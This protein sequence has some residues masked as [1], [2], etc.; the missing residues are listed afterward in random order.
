MFHLFRSS[1]LLVAAHFFVSTNTYPLDLIEIHPLSSTHKDSNNGQFISKFHFMAP[2][3]CFKKNSFISG[4]S[5]ISHTN[6]QSH[7]T[8]YDDDGFLTLSVCLRF[9]QEFLLQHN[10]TKSQSFSDSTSF[11]LNQNILR[12]DLFIPLFT[13][14]INKLL[15]EELDPSNTVHNPLTREQASSF[16]K[17]CEYAPTYETFFSTFGNF[18]NS[19]FPFRI[20]QAT[21]TQLKSSTEGIFKISSLGIHNTSF[22]ERDRL[23]QSS[24]MNCNFTNILS[25]LQKHLLKL[26]KS[27]FIDQNSRN[28]ITANPQQ[29]KLISQL[30]NKI[31][32]RQDLKKNH[33]LSGIDIWHVLSS[34]ALLHKDTHLL[35]NYHSLGLE[36]SPSIFSSL[37]KMIK[38]SDLM[39]FYSLFL[40][41]NDLDKTVIP[42]D[43][44]EIEVWFSL[45]SNNKETTKIINARIASYTNNLFKNIIAENDL[46][47]VDMAFYTTSYLKTFWKNKFD[48]EISSHFFNADNT[49][50]TIKFLKKNNLNVSYS[51]SNNNLTLMLPLKNNAHYMIWMPDKLPKK[52]PYLCPNQ[53]FTTSKAD[54]T[55]PKLD[56]ESATNLITALKDLNFNTLEG[57]YLSH[58]RLQSIFQKVKLRTTLDGVEAAAVTST[59]LTSSSQDEASFLINKPHMISIVLEA[60]KDFFIPMFTGWIGNL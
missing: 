42:N 55:Y 31:L 30:T 3:N 26:P 16:F 49:Q 56:V 1:F 2:D 20:F 23:W 17:L 33:L 27:L 24:L 50:T 7:L 28:V 19:N 18:V 51:I 9:F 12:P 14:S 41:P 13:L 32:V 57:P 47:N 59:R 5:P 52:L 6:H 40:F 4:I 25:K 21:Q 60:D 45:G 8:V 58:L 11:S 38:S 35:E 37:K 39:Q 15:Q 48:R 53:K 22:S 29:I 36:F 43:L 34:L 44:K 46:E 10:L 54:I